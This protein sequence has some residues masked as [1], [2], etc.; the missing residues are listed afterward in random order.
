MA[1]ISTLQ[2]RYPKE[3]APVGINLDNE[4]ATAKSYV[5][6]KKLNWPQLYDEGGLESRL[7]NEMGILSLP[8]MLLIDK[9][10]RVVNRN[11]HASEIETELKK[12]VK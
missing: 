10:G 3:F 5:T 11:I 8:T 1:L 9:N 2:N 4:L 12:L 7:A 6:Q